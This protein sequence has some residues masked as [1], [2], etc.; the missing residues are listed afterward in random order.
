MNCPICLEPA[1]DDVEALRCG[2]TLHTACFNTLRCHDGTRCP[3]C[4]TAF[5]E[6]TESDPN[7]GEVFMDLTE[8]LER[9]NVVPDRVSRYVGHFMD[10]FTVARVR[11]LRFV[12]GREAEMQYLRR[13]TRHYIEGVHAKARNGAWASMHMCFPRHRGCTL[14]IRRALMHM[15]HDD[16]PCHMT[17]T[18]CAPTCWCAD[19]ADDNECACSRCDE[20][21]YYRQVDRAARV[22]A[23]WWNNVLE[24][25]PTVS[26][27][28]AS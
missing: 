4:R 5:V 27:G 20:A 11:M 2:H 8:Y 14:H 21:R 10:R 26:S 22:V 16:L 25:N 9:R 17:H 1:N 15:L 28:T 19:E 7:D 3:V 23:T 18:I 12:R 6:F 13:T 24:K